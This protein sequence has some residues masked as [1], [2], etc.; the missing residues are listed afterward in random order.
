MRRLPPPQARAA[1]ADKVNNPLTAS[2]PEATGT[3][4]VAAPPGAVPP[5][6][7]PGEVP[8]VVAPAAAV[9]EAAAPAGGVITVHT[10]VLE[11]DVSLRGGE[12]SRAD[13]LH[14]PVVKGQAE[15]VRLLRTRASATSTCC[16][17]AWPVPAPMPPS[18]NTPRTSPTSPATSAASVWKTASTSCACR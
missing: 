9:S 17:P 16:R 18:T 14:Y 7:G 4:Q 11:V 12:L 13:L 1:E 8:T 15:A 6:A 3:A 10:D 2:V 5:A